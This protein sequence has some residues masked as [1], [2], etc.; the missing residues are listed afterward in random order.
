[1]YKLFYRPK[2]R[3]SAAADFIPFFDNGIFHLFYLFDHRNNEKY[4][5]GVTWYKVETTDF[6]SFNDKGEM[7]SRGSKQEYDMWGFTGSVIKHQNK[8]H[9]FYTG[10]NIYIKT[11]GYQCECIMHAESDDLDHWTK[12]PEDTFFAP[13]GYD[14]CDFRDPYVYF[15]EKGNCFY[16]LICVRNPQGNALRNG[17][18]LR[19]KS[20]DLKKW[21]FDKPIYTPH[22]FQTHEC[23]DLFNIGDR[24]YLIFSE[25]SDR[26]VT[27]Y[28]VSDSPNGPWRKPKNDTFDGRAYYAAKTA[29]DGNK[30]YLFGWVPTRM[31][32]K[33]NGIWMWG[34]NLVVHEVYNNND[35]DLVVKTPQTILDYFKEEVYNNHF[36]MFEPYG[37][38]VEQITNN[39]P[40]TFKLSFTAKPD[41]DCDRFGILFKQNAESDKAYE[42]RFDLAN[43]MLSINRFPCFPQNELLTYQL[44]RK[45]KKANQ[46]HVTL[47]GDNDVFVLYV[48]DEIA[49]SFRT[50]E[51]FGD[52][53]AVY[54]GD[55]SVKFENIILTK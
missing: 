11:F 28:R 47:I 37:S 19:M 18:T 52:G 3:N 43:E 36:T 34:G 26:N 46:Y 17:E 1:M 54:V 49:L 22:A 48:N 38:L 35:G 15:D 5:E 30:R 2:E 40:I 51:H 14:C 9:I 21:E 13:K 39:A 23:P 16:M 31:D 20:F 24:W 32:G 44:Q 7:I 55:G 50:C 12:I 10:H 53:L 42:Y 8:Y 45:I 29:F 25:Y 4:G 6:I 33:D 27:C 41:D